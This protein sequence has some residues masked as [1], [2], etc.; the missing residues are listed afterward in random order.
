MFKKRFMP[1]LDA[2]DGISAIGGVAEPEDEASGEE[3]TDEVT[4][5][6]DTEVIPEVEE[7]V[8]PQQ[9][10]EENA[11]FAEI[12]RKADAEINKLRAELDHERQSKADRINEVVNNAYKGSVNPY[13]NRPI[14]T[15]ADY[16]EYQQMYKED[17]LSQLGVSKDFITK[18]IENNPIVKEAQRI[19]EA[20]K[21]GQAK[22]LFDSRLAE[23]TKLNPDIK[24]IDDLMKMPNKAEF[25]DYV[26]NKHYDILDAYK[27]VN[28]D[29]K[30]KP[31]TSETKEHLI[32]TGGQGGG[33]VGLEIPGELLDYYKETFPKETAAQLRTR[34]NRVLK[35]QGE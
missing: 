3:V 33:S 19:L 6:D 20:Q 11:K 2:D 5:D 4:E 24:S 27:L 9:T 13:T 18:E 12:R 28:G 10:A 21:A 14:E 30:K 15:E 16:E 1:F 32:K 26:L 34:Y 25:D 17:V 31:N 22:A 23:I 8:K 29:T 7:P 35:R